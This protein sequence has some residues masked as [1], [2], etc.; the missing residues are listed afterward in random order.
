MSHSAV[1][2]KNSSGVAMKFQDKFNSAELKEM[3]APTSANYEL[4]DNCD[5]KDLSTLIVKL[6]SHGNF[7]A[8]MEWFN[9]QANTDFLSL[10]SSE[11]DKMRREGDPSVV[12]TV[13]L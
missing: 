3:T 6:Y 4:L 7:L 1:D 8:I 12:V 11:L 10:S 2:F 9:V 5:D 13:L